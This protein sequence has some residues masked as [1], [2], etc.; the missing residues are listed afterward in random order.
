MIGAII[1]KKKVRST[2]DSLNWRNLDA[3]LANWSEAATY[4]YPGNLSAS[5]EFKG[6]ESIKEWYEKFMEQFPQA[7]FDIKN[8]GAQKMCPVNFRTNSVIVEW[9]GLFTNRDRKE[10]KNSGVTVF[11]MEKGKA[12]KVNQYIFNAEIDRRAWGEA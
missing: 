9:D 11:N 6:K 8:I 1:A 3:F 12:I 4:V 10:F 5:G 2:F 7:I